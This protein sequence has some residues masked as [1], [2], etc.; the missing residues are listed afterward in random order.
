MRFSL[1][2]LLLAGTGALAQEAPEM[3]QAASIC[4]PCHGADG[5]AQMAN[6]PNL[7]GQNEAYLKN[8]LRAY[9]DGR[10]TGGTAGLML[11]PAKSISDEDV[12]ALSGYYAALPAGGK[13]KD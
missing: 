5:I 7:A 9:R 8:A 12:D 1:V 3:P 2:A 13:R 4:T 6:Y 10:R 11:G